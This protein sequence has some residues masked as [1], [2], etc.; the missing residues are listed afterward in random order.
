MLRAG[1]LLLLLGSVSALAAPPAWPEFRGPT[2]QG[3]SLAEELPLHWS[4]TENI[5]W[6]T[7][8]PGRGWSSPAILDGKA[9]M[10]TA[11]DAGRSLRAIAVDAA[12]GKI[13]HDVEVF[14]LSGAPPK[15]HEKNSHASPTPILEENRVYV[16]FGSQGTAALDGD[17]KV[18]W[19]NQEHH[20]VQGHGNG[21]SPVVWKDLII[22][23]CDGIDR[24]FIAALDKNTGETRWTKSRGKSRMSY[25]TPLIIETDQGPQL[26]SPG[27]DYAA[28]YDPSTGEE[29][30]RITYDGFSLVPR[31]VY[32]NGLVYIASGFYG[33]ILFAVKPDGR[34]DVTASKVVWK[35][36]RG[37]PLTSSPIVS[38]GRLYMVSDNGI[39]SC[40]NA[41]TGQ[42]LW[43]ARLGGNFSA[44]PLLAG[45][46]LYFTSETGETTVIEDA[47]KYHELAKNQIEG[48]TLASFAVD[49][50]ALL[51]RSGTDL[52]RI[53]PAR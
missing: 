11:T 9:W 20:F 38:G 29:I 18:L 3:V 30:W 50:T 21:G 10:T 36:T 34:G 33:P 52:Y 6:K 28:S 37:V 47:P 12:S 8:I 23:N 40:L 15:K 22:F 35:E 49:G 1:P 27:G 25:A 53:E 4:E 48:D 39:A 42:R 24:Q 41:L 14:N 44:S 5:A 43:Q 17:G 19:R 51:L 13:L 32:A 46:R 2:G 31:P 45:N 7:P 16:H 26:I